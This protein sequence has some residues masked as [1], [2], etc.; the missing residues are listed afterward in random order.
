[1]DSDTVRADNWRIARETL[2]LTY[3]WDS[4]RG[5]KTEMFDV[6]NSVE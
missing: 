4:E 5:G 3:S 6:S 1:M 2:E